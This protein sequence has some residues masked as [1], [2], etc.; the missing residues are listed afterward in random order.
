[1]FQVRSHQ[2]RRLSNQRTSRKTNLWIYVG[3]LF[4]WP[5]SPVFGKALTIRWLP[6]T[7]LLWT[8]PLLLSL[9]CFKP[10]GHQHSSHF[11]SKN[12]ELANKEP[13]WMKNDEYLIRFVFI[14][15]WSS[16][17]IKN[18]SPKS[19]SQRQTLA[20]WRQ[21]PLFPRVRC[22]PRTAGVMVDILMGEMGVAPKPPWYRL[23]NG[24][25]GYLP[26]PSWVLKNHDLTKNAQNWKLIGML[27]SNMRHHSVRDS[28]DF[29][30]VD[31]WKSFTS[32]W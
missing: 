8:D 13:K 14:G 16:L 17:L 22:W 10:V 2:T 4:L 19:F 3:L 30:T 18:L 21:H 1:M 27:W 12:G 7:P 25:H 9:V 28:L 26:L 31:G 11:D 32:W 20:R 24:S 29:A 5:C 15:S 6:A 23:L